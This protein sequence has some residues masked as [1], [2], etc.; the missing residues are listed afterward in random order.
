MNSL[1]PSKHFG[2]GD[3][4]VCFAWGKKFRSWT[5]VKW[6]EI[7]A[8]K[9]PESQVQPISVPKDVSII[10]K[11]PSNIERNHIPTLYGNYKVKG[12]EMAPQKLYHT[13]NLREYAV[14]SNSCLITSL[15]KSIDGWEWDST[16]CKTPGVKPY[17]S[18]MRFLDR[19]F[20]N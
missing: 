2:S 15:G 17:A 9:P 14:S 7:I 6:T 1:L 4:H 18:K 3:K 19:E 12:M 10:A 16:A 20:T 8:G 11:P 5:H 13:I